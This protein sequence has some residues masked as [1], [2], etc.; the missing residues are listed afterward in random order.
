VLFVRADAAAGGDGTRDAPLSDLPTAIGLVPVG[1]TLAIGV[2]AYEGRVTVPHAMTIAGACA[3]S[4][5]LTR[6]GISALTVIGAQDIDG[7]VAL[8]DLTIRSTKGDRLLSEQTDVTMEAV[9]FD[10]AGWVH[11]DGDVA[12][13]GVVCRDFRDAAFSALNIA[14]AGDVSMSRVSVEGSATGGISVNPEG[15]LVAADVVV[16]NTQDV[17]FQGNGSEVRLARIVVEDA[18]EGGVILNGPGSDEDIVIRRITRVDGLSVGYFSPVDRQITRLRVEDAG[19]VGISL[20]YGESALSDVLVVGR[21]TRDEVTAGRGI[22]VAGGARVTMERF[23]ISQTADLAIL[24]DGAATALTL[25]DL[26]VDTVRTAAAGN[27]GRCIH[28][29]VRASV[30]VARGRLIRCREAAVTASYAAGVFLRDVQVERTLPLFCETGACE[31]PRAG[32]GLVALEMRGRID[33]E[34]F[35]ITESA[36][37][38]VQVVVGGE[39]DLRD[40]TIEASP[41]GVNVQVDGYDLSRVMDRVVFRNN[42]VNLDS[43]ELPVPDAM[44]STSAP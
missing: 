24:A 7:P 29:Q 35:L 16:R 31:D 19:D 38:G 32:L 3:E 14:G 30:D 34:R 21:Q 2:G 22:E 8:R 27:F 12:M 42:G 10:G 41:V 1:G 15:M 4:V 17:A 26:T 44:T 43:A 40:G 39:V 6:E 5:V 9:V 37:A 28:A 20:G 23:A 13:D 25:S 36:L 18:L 33:A 11:L